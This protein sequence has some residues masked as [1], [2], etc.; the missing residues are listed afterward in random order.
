[1]HSDQF[2]ATL[3]VVEFHPPHLAALFYFVQ[4]IENAG[5]CFYIHIFNPLL[6]FSGNLTPNLTSDF[7]AFRYISST[8]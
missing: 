5:L 8:P 1:M 2:K 3:N 6:L 7:H 4:L